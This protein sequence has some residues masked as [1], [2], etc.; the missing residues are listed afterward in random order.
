MINFM[1]ARALIVHLMCA[2]KLRIATCSKKMY[3]SLL[4]HVHR[5]DNHVVGW[6]TASPFAGIHTRS[7]LK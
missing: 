2:S 4:F 6:G 7:A 3:L 5:L 1:L